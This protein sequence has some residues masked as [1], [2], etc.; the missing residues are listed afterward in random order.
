MKLILQNLIPNHWELAIHC[1]ASTIKA[2][3]ELCMH[4]YFI[5]RPIMKVFSMTFGWL[6]KNL[7]SICLDFASSG[8]VRKGN[9]ER[10]MFGRNIWKHLQ[11]LSKAVVL[12]YSVHTNQPTCLF[13]WFPGSSHSGILIQEVLQVGKWPGF[14]K[15]G[16]WSSKFSE[17]KIYQ[18]G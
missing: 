18:T 8:N 16:Q 15:S 12:K 4:T 11:K 6:S 13:K 10:E 9:Q 2:C 17:V 3:I 14:A 7:V 5:F 1:V